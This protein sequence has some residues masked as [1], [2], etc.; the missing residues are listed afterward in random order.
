M[1]RS[2]YRSQR[3]AGLSLLLSLVLIVGSLLLTAP[4]F[5][6]PF[7]GGRRAAA[8]GTITVNVYED[9]NANGVKDTAF[10]QT[11]VGLQGIT[12]TA[13]CANGT[14]GA[15]GVTNN[16]GVATL[17]HTCADPAPPLNPAVSHVRV[18]V[19]WNPA[20]T[21]FAGLQ[22]S[23]QAAAGTQPNRTTVQF[24]SSGA[25]TV[26]VGL[27][28]P[29]DYV[30]QTA[31]LV[32]VTYANGT[33]NNDLATYKSI[34]RVPWAG[35]SEATLDQKSEHRRGVGRGVLALAQPDL[36]LG[37]GEAPRRAGAGR[38]RRH[39]FD[40]PRRRRQHGD[41]QCG[42]RGLDPG[43]RAR[44]SWATAPAHRTMRRCSPRSARP[45]SA[46]W[47]SRMTRPSCG[48]PTCSTA[49]CTACRSARRR[50]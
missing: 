34:V 25:Q 45:A 11:D 9:F 37:V 7:L 5:A 47:T 27:I 18:E 1:D 31:N 23:A 14:V 15:T 21:P 20:L 3:P 24:V 4:A 50:R 43:R 46:T 8:G 13:Y 30:G 22:P 12:A 35:G 38:D 10:G 49:T 26:N 16:L 19:T 48:T 32:T 44:A 17:T 41:R 33:A 40:P 2:G 29:T 6:R 39:L 42:R 36:H 28:R